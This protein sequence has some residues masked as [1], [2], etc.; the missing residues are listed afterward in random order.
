MNR[1]HILL[2]GYLCLLMVLCINMGETKQPNTLS[3]PAFHKLEEKQGCYTVTVFDDGNKIVLRDFSFTGHTSIGGILKETDDSVNKLEIAQIK[4]ISILNN[5]YKSKRY[6]NQEVL[7]AEVTIKNGKK[8]TD[9]LIPKHIIICGIEVSTDMQKAWVLS[10][11]NKVIIEGP[12]PSPEYKEEKTHTISKKTQK[13][14]TKKKEKNTNY[15]KEEPI[16]QLQ[17]EE[18]KAQV[19]KTILSSFLDIIE[20]IAGFI[21]SIINAI[22]KLFSSK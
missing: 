5:D 7:L 16:K 13:K 15:E 4:E 9:L 3:G 21:R 1:G 8:I 10:K 22:F 2:S 14:S 6:P 19:T 20:A 18:P 12:C 17:Q 11:I